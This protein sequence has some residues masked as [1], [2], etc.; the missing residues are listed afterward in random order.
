MN[1]I[2]SGMASLG[3]EKSVKDEKRK[4][5]A[6]ETSS[7]ASGVRKTAAGASPR[8]LTAETAPATRWYTRK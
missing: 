7:S 4:P 8:L 6:P 2:A 1:R 5:I 3:Q